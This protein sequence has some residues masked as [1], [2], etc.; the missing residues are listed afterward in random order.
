[1]GSMDSGFTSTHDLV[2]A[3]VADLLE[4]PLV[5]LALTHASRTVGDAFWLI[6]VL[7]SVFWTGVLYALILLYQRLGPTHNAKL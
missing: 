7:N 5:K 4:Y 1:M 2:I 3:R 6:L